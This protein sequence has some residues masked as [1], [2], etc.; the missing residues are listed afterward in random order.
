MSP[1]DANDELFVRIADRL[2]ALSD[3]TRL[4]IL[5]ALEDGER[6]VTEILE[7]VGG[8][9]ANVS[10]HLS[11]MRLSGVVAS[12]RAGTSVHYRVVDPAAFAICRTVCDSLEQH[13]GDEH[14]T[15]L[16]ARAAQEGRG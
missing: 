7:L 5:H 1:D 3:P 14:R 9:Q 6:T 12:R 15:I 8:S 2:K 16:Q 10:K 11:R 13:A 4:K